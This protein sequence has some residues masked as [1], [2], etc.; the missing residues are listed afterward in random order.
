MAFRISTALKNSL[1]LAL[2]NP[3]AGTS[4]V[5]GPASL[6]IYEGVQP[7]S[8]DDDAGT[9]SLLCEISNIGWNATTSGTASFANTSG[10]VGTAAMDGTAGWGRMENING[11]GTCRVDG[12]V[13]TQVNNVFTINVNSFSSGGEITLLSADIYMA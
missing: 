10:Y 1:C 8:A 9:Y 2:I 4:G 3:L 12:D 5:S 13:G 6:K 11:L 7:A